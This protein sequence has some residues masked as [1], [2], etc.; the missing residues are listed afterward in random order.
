[1]DK[2]KH[3]EKTALDLVRGA[4]RYG[5]YL[6]HLGFEVAGV[7]DWLEC[8]IPRV[9]GALAAMVRAAAAEMARQAPPDHEGN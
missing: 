4:S 5:V 9:R 6:S 8:Q 2:L 7:A 3:V 1:M